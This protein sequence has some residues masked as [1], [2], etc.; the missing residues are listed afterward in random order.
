MKASTPAGNTRSSEAS[1]QRQPQTRRP[2]PGDEPGL[3][4]LNVDGGEDEDWEDML[5]FSLARLTLTWTT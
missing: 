4:A 5:V 3:V 1:R 2:P